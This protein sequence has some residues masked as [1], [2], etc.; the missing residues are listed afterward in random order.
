MIYNIVLI[1][2]KMIQ[3]LDA[4][5]FCI[6][7]NYN[8]HQVGHSNTLSYIK[9]HPLFISLDIRKMRKMNCKCKVYKGST[10]K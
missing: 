3:S 1:F 9:Q 6:E 8:Y 7:T 4:F 5:C 2:K 10:W